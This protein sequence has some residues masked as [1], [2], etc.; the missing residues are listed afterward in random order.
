MRN[1]EPRNPGACGKASSEARQH[2]TELHQLALPLDDARPFLLHHLGGGPGH[3]ALVAELG[4]AADDFRAFPSDRP[5]F[6]PL[7]RA[8][9]R[10]N[11]SV[12]AGATTY[13]VPKG[14]SHVSSESG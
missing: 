8:K 10:H 4:L 11:L 7:L 5:L 6:R 3:E 12:S 14:T 9:I 1:H 2:V 13:L